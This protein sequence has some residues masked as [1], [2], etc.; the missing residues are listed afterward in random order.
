MYKLILTLF[1]FALISGC[2]QEAEEKMADT[3]GG[4]SMEKASTVK[5]KVSDSEYSKKYGSA[6]K[7]AMSAKKN[8]ESD[9]V[10]KH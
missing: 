2:S 3:A 5:D 9:T 1:I 8:N 6:M 4:E 7:K 10:D